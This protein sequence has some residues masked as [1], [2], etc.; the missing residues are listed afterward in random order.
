MM[1]RN[2]P[3]SVG[4]VGQCFTLEVDKEEEEEEDLSG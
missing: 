3:D 4:K 2:M 1:I